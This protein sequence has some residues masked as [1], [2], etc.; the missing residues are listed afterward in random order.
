MLRTFDNDGSHEEQG[1]QDDNDGG[2]EVLEAFRSRLRVNESL[3]KYVIR[4]EMKLALAA[5]ISNVMFAELLS[6]RESCAEKIC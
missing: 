1:Y 4:V 3:K 6:F 5:K 2:M